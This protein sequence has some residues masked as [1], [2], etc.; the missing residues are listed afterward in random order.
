MYVVIAG[1]NFQLVQTPLTFTSFL[2][3]C[4]VVGGIFGA[5]WEYMRDPD[6]RFPTGP[7]FRGAVYGATFAVLVFVIG[8]SGT[9]DALRNAEGPHPRHHAGLLVIPAW[10]LLLTAT[11]FLAVMTRATS[12]EHSQ[13]KGSERGRTSET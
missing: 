6:H 2:P 4:V 9:V 1:S 8:K 12:G 10:I 7:S 11:I 3:F 13:I 5:L